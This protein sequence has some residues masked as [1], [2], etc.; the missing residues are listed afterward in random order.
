MHD[1]DRHAHAR[2][3]HDRSRSDR[4]GCMP[5]NWAYVGDSSDVE[6]IAVIHRALDLG[7]TLLDTSDAYGPFTNEKLVGRALAAAEAKP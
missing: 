1:E 4:L 7:V 6:S 2:V 5:M 3:E